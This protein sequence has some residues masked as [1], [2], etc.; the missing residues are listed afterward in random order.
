M[1]YKAKSI[2]ALHMALG[3]LPD[4]MRVEVDP[5]IEV[6]AKT[7]GE[8]RKATAWPENLAVTTPQERHADSAVRISKVNIAT[9]TTPKR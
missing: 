8:L 2:A 6:T 9:R 5:G 3:S 4:K 1:R 7:V